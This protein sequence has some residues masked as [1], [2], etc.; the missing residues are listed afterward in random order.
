MNHA[1]GHPGAG[2]RLSPHFYTAD[3]QLEHAVET[4]AEILETD[5][6]RQHENVT[7]VVT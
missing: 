4:M 6:W 2:V 5:A 7:R 3:A 1:L